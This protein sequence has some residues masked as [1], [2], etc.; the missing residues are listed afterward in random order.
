MLSLIILNHLRA[1]FGNQ[2]YEDAS[3]AK[4]FSNLLAV[5]FRRF[6]L[7]VYW[8]VTRRVWSLCPVELGDV[9]PNGNI[10]GRS[11]LR[12][13]A[14]DGMFALAMAM[15]S[16]KRILEML[17]NMYCRAYSPNHTLSKP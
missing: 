12:Q 10:T 11:T 1:C 9:G 3:A 4:C 15:R 2:L 5:G 8:D 14:A 16:L 17:I 6:E 13:R 7:D